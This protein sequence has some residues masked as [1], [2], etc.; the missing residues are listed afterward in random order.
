M[1]AKGFPLCSLSNCDTF[2]C[3]NA[4]G[5]YYGTLN[6]GLENCTLAWCQ[7]FQVHHDYYGHVTLDFEDCK[8]AMCATGCFAGVAAICLRLQPRAMPDQE[9]RIPSTLLTE[10]AGWSWVWPA[11]ANQLVLPAVGMNIFLQVGNTVKWMITLGHATLVGSP[12]LWFMVVVS[13]KQYS[14]RSKILQQI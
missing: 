6:L 11:W 13:T 8:S 14:L 7:R 4:S 3:E 12:Y 9:P 2:A 1:A 10:L 5:Y